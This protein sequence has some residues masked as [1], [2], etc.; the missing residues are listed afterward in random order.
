MKGDILDAFAC[1]RAIKGAEAVI[2]TVG[3]SGLE[4]PGEAQSQGMRNI[5]AAMTKLNVKRVLGVAGSGIL[6][7]P[8]GGL[9]H[10]QTNFIAAFRPVSVRHQQAWEA[11]RGSDRDWTMV[12]CPDIVPGERKG[13]YRVIEDRLPEQGKTISVEDAADFLL[14][15]LREGKHLKKRVGLAY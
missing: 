4:D 10:D 9:R 6:D 1:E 12:A 14:K 13:A 8:A 3:G 7:S 5:I 15:E 11:M 2:S